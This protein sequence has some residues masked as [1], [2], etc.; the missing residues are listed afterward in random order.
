VTR[1]VEVHIERLALPPGLSA[2]A[3][4]RELAR[5][6]AQEQVAARSASAGT[7]RAELGGPATPGGVARAVHDGIKRCTT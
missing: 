1:P 2:G 7:V 3:I 4:R 5:L 6:V